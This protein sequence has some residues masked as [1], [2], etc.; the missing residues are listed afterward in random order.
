MGTFNVEMRIGDPDGERWTP[1]DALVDTGA[2]IIS[3]PAS[4]LRELGIAPIT[5]QEFQFAQG[6]VREMEIGRTWV[7]FAGRE[8][9]TLVL[10]NEDDSPPLLGA[11][12]LEEAFLGVDPVGRRLIPVRGLMMS[13]QSPQRIRQLARKGRIEAHPLP[14]RRMVES[15]PRRVHE[16]AT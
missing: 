16:V 7:R 6:E 5:R 1:F 10:F 8:V 14:R 11:L 2:S 12:A 4:A 15:Q 9:L 3:A 13:A